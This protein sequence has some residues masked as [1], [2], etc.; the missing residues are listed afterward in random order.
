MKS[1]QFVSR[2][3]VFTSCSFKE[4]IEANLYSP[5]ES[6]T[7]RVLYFLLEVLFYWSFRPVQIVYAFLLRF[8]LSS[9]LCFVFETVPF[10]NMFISDS[11]SFELTFFA[12]PGL[13]YIFRLLLMWTFPE[14]L[15]RSRTQRIVE[16][17]Q[18]RVSSEEWFPEEAHL[19]AKPL[20]RRR[21]RK[22][23]VL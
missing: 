15:S 10:Q 13:I 9:S 20:C 16:Y 12:V 4:R 2:C 21:R 14:K 6:V 1:L 7:R 8:P 18:L 22:F 5:S 19:Y 3:F 23:H 11:L 17:W